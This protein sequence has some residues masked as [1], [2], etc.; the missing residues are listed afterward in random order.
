MSVEKK[1]QMR[2][3]CMVRVRISECREENEFVQAYDE[4]VK[5]VIEE[6]RIINVLK[7]NETEISVQKMD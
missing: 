7:C 3:G 5:L 1:T 4:T 6:T 2:F